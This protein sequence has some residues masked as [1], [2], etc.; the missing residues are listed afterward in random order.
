MWYDATVAA[1]LLEAD[2]SP[3]K[4]MNGYAL[5]AGQED[6]RASGW[7]WSWAL[8]IPKTHPIHGLAWKYISWATGP[9]YIEAAGDLI[10]GGWAAIPPGT[11]RSTY[12]IPQYQ[13]AAARLRRPDAGGDGGR[14]D[15]QPRH[16]DRDRVCPVCSTSAS[17]EFQDV[18]NRCT[19][20]FSG[21]IAGR[22]DI[23]DALSALPGHRL[24]GRGLTR[25]RPVGSRMTPGPH[26]RPRPSADGPRATPDASRCA[27]PGVGGCRC[28]R[29]SLFTIV[30]HADPVRD[31]HLVQ[32]HRLEDRPADP[33]EKFVGL[34]N[35]TQSVDDQ[36]FRDA[37]GSTRRD[38]GVV[39]HR[40][41][42]SSARCS[43]CSSTA[44]FFGRGFV[45]TLLITPFLIMPVVAGL[46]W[47]NQM[48][49][50]LY[51]VVNW[52]IER[53]GFD[54]I[55]FVSR[56]PHAVDRDRP[57]LAVDAVHDADHAR[58]P[59]EPAVAT[60]SRP[61]RSTGPR[62]SGRSAS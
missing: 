30:A 45:R 29:R 42:S 7:L 58:R 28:C 59:A 62:R 23:D 11:R 35:Y 44:T 21:V 51:G 61:R 60:C 47:K 25:P 24:A 12:E 32:P 5:G 41:R 53:L 37:R 17:R 15:R 6:R 22:V 13:E 57:R 56:Y 36:F 50:G 14:A 49:S 38:D 19:E 34:D 26:D 43:R 4:G 52:V 8:A 40:S 54:S 39:G 16:D 20:Q 55:E 31:E 46:I 33:D 3:V 9:R 2:D 10:P 48:F 1:G 18:G 27:T